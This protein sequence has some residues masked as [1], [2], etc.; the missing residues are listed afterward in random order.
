MPIKAPAS[1][2]TSFRRL[3]RELNYHDD[4]RFIG[5]PQSGYSG[6][7]ISPDETDKGSSERPRRFP[8]E[9]ARDRKSTH[10]K[11]KGGSE[12]MG[13]P[14]GATRRPPVILCRSIKVVTAIQHKDRPHTL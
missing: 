3:D 4:L 11:D 7:R 13:A 1:A 14:E 10:G 9:D 12:M 6:G 2:S 5:L 8:D